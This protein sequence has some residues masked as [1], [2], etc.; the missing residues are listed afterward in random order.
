MLYITYCCSVFEDRNN[1]KSEN[2]YFLSDEM[3]HD[4]PM[5]HHSLKLVMKNMKAN[6]PQVTDVECFTDGCSSQYKSCKTSLNLCDVKRI[7]VELK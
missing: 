3:E 1:V 5:V 2:F 6:Y 4:V 7:L